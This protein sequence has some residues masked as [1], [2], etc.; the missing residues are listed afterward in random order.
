MFRGLC[1]KS[2]HSAQALPDV[3]YGSVF[4][5]GWVENYNAYGD[6]PSTK[7]T[8]CLREVFGLTPDQDLLSYTVHTDDADRA[9]AEAYLAG[10]KTGTRPD[11]RYRVV[12]CHH[13]GNTSPWKKNLEDVDL[14]PLADWCA[15][16]GYSLVVLDWDGRATAELT[17]HPA[18][19][20]CSHIRAKE[21]WKDYGT[22]DGSRIKALVDR[23]AA[24]VGVDSG[25]G[26]VAGA[27]TTPAVI[28]WKL[29][30]PAQF[31]DKAPNVLHLLPENPRG[32]QPAGHDHVWKYFTS[33]ARYVSYQTS[34][35]GRCLAEAV[36]RHAE[37]DPDAALRVPLLETSM[38]D[39]QLFTARSFD[40]E[41]YEQH[42]N[43]GLDYLN[44][45]DWQVQYA[46]WVV[47]NLKTH[48]KRVLDV[49]CACGSITLGLKKAGMH[50]WGV[51]L[52]NY[53]IQKGRE[54]FPDLGL[55]VC[56]AVNL[57]LFAD[58]YFHVV[59]HHQVAEHWKKE[60]VPFILR[61]IHRV[62][63]P[64]GFV[65]G[66]FDTQELF[67]RQSRRPELEDPTNGCVETFNW[68]RQQYEEA[69]FVRAVEVEGLLRSDP[70]CFPKKHHYD[71]DS[72][73]Y[74]KPEA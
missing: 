2:F 26:H 9:A 33:H 36:V 35:L 28:Y 69:G 72:C 57:H 18:V 10:L 7:A 43:N 41:Y 19:V 40:R 51:D 4:N 53:M 59:H 65:F 20:V 42:R 50:A 61:E 34:A 30:H 6:C 1:A 29:H 74:Y 55:A 67:N 8:N 63:A 23:V 25:P 27:S 38:S 58:A 49:G 54:T 48:G 3:S 46:R 39:R 12:L 22:G 44:H 21:L 32:V 56:D 45:G 15:A 16:S 71:W 73:V 13:K 60:L 37:L 17:R 64:G 11:G 66:V 52:N 62:L 5:L 24:F 31:Y 47:D 14:L 70:Q 68:W